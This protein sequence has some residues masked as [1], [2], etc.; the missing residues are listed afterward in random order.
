[1]NTQRTI[2]LML[3]LL[4]PAL[5][6]AQTDAPG[7][8]E[9]APAPTFADVSRTVDEQ[10]R[11][12][13][14]EYEAVKQRIADEKIPLS[15]KLSE[16]E[17]E[18]VRVREELREIRRRYDSRQ[19]E[20]SN[21][22]K[23]IDARKEEGGYLSNLLA[24]YIRNLEAR[25]HIAEMQRYRDIRQA[26]LDAAENAQLS[27]QEVFDA[28][29]RLVDTSVDRLEE[30]LG[31][32]TF[33]GQAVT[34]DGAVKP[35]TFVLVG[36]AALFR[37]EDGRAVGT[38]EQRLNSP[39]PVIV[40]FSDPAL[41]EM[42]SKLAAEKAGRVPFDPTLGNAHVIEQTQ[43]TLWQHV[44]KGGPVMVP[45]FALAGAA[46]L[47]ALYKWVRLSFVGGVSRRRLN[48][49]IEAVARGD[50]PAAADAAQRIGGPTGEMLKAGVDHLDEPRD[51]VEEIMYE[52]VLAT[53]LKLNSL[54]PFIV[55]TA[56]SA[57][58][59]GL[60]GTVTGIINT[61]NLI[62]VFGSGDVKT[63]SSGISEALI[64][65]KF[66]LIVAIPALL[67]HAF[68]SRKARGI[69]DGMEKAA[70]ALINQI[71]LKPRK[72]LDEAA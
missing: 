24:D 16:R 23:D 57:P 45:I 43:D 19:L 60:L 35:G 21:F 61:F 22:K 41:A 51:L 62:K 31:G 55:I 4:G 58:L 13:T 38:A 25:L 17:A 56:A 59:L 39:E 11:Q 52:K 42:A 63:L 40:P 34:E 64:T 10:L 7:G 70:V 33:A 5:A 3:L 30:L 9:K 37:S 71:A 32:T 54:L 49:L 6:R 12:A 72:P 26:A 67:L 28:Q 36:P 68:L 18:L 15:R 46:L 47:V 2:V 14:E 48:A 50:R 29:I 66:G 44:Q 65:T 8:A 1:M 20:L 69:V 27:Q 53:R